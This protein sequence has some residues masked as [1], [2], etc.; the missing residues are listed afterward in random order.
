MRVL[1]LMDEATLNM[2]QSGQPPVAGF[3]HDKNL[4]Q[5]AHEALRK[6]YSV[7]IGSIQGDKVSNR[8]WD[9]T[10]VYPLWQWQDNGVGYVDVR[11]DLVVGVFLE[12]MNVRS[13]FPEA[14]IIAIQAAI[15]WAESPQNFTARYLFDTITAIRFNVDFIVTQNQRMKNLLDVFFKFVA[16][17]DVADR[18]LVAPLGI[19]EEERRDVEDRRVV[20]SRMGLSR[21]SI[22]IVNSGGVWN[23]TDFNS[24]LTAYC[25][26]CVKVRSDLKLFIMGFQQ[27]ENDYHT[28]YIDHAKSVISSNQSLIG[29]NIV[30][31]DDWYAASKVV[32]SFTAAA[33]LGL[34]VNLPSLENWQSYRLRF[35]DYL[36]F[37][38]PAINTTGDTISDEIGAEALFIVR[39]GD[40]D[41]YQ[42][43][44]A[45]IER[46]R[47]VI[48]RKAEAMK[49]LAAEF[50]SRKTYGR[51]IDQ[52]VRTPKR[53][54]RD[55]AEW[56]ETVLDFAE[57]RARG[58]AKAR[59]M[60]RLSAMLD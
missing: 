11:P 9:V 58:M 28:D 30:I 5:F 39:P 15:H 46:D 42:A 60:E 26:Y 20:R 35:L 27:P 1:I 50:D 7:M 43:V 2:L 31:E 6:G 44:L 4:F 23:W 57:N 38:I 51:V 18:I 52:I 54:D 34:N 33:D 25:G 17:T 8:Y 41:G 21:S 56:P 47:S 13:V 48:A 22:A 19:V 36:Y 10:A 40:V 49:A 55:F 14:K 3:S 37:G 32:K 59:F 29:K 45:A 12:G 24:F 53:S 16:K